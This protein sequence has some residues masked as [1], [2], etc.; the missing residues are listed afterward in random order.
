MKFSKHTLVTTAI[1]F[2]GK[3]IFAQTPYDSFAPEQSKKEMLKLAQLSYKIY[4]DDTL[5]NIKYLEFDAETM[6]VQYYNQN[7]SA[8]SAYAL[9]MKEMKWSSIDPMA[10]KYPQ[11]TP[12]NFVDNNPISNIDK[13][14]DSTLYYSSTG[15]LLFAS[16]DNLENMLVIIDASNVEAFGNRIES[17][18]MTT[19]PKMRQDIN[20]NSFN[21]SLRNLGSQKYATEMFENFYNKNKSDQDQTAAT[22]YMNEHGTWLYKD[23]NGVVRTGAENQVTSASGGVRQE[24]DAANSVG[25]LHTHPNAGKPADMGLLYSHGPSPEDENRI[26]STGYFDVI[27]SPKQIYLYNSTKN[28]TIILNL[29]N[30][31]SSDDIVPADGT[32]VKTQ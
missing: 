14:G 11:L 12:Y 10:A 15:V 29:K 13:K 4:N 26:N 27:V 18:V 3:I 5:S 23:A 16:R 32:G 6:T 19:D 24:P 17:A 2:M 20:S 7:D 9:N 31:F 21:R 30:T 1:I 28:A 22:G 25:R 8:V